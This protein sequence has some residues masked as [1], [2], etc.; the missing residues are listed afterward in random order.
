MIKGI[1]LDANPQAMP[2]ALK[3]RVFNAISFSGGI[4]STYN[5]I[6]V[7]FGLGIM[8]S[9]A[10][11]IGRSLMK[12]V[13]WNLNDGK[14]FP[15][16]W[17]IFVAGS[18][19]AIITR[20]SNDDHDITRMDSIIKDCNEKSHNI[21]IGII[22]L[23]SDGIIDL[24]A[25]VA[26]IEQ[27][28]AMHASV[29]RDLEDL[30]TTLQSSCVNNDHV[31]CVLPI[32][33]IDEIEHVRCIQTPFL[34]YTA[35]VSEKLVPLLVQLGIRLDEGHGKAII[36]TP[37]HTFYVDLNTSTL[38]AVSLP[39]IRCRKYPCRDCFVK[40]CIV[41]ESE[42]KRGFASAELGLTASDVFVLSMIFAIANGQV[43]ASISSQFPRDKPY[44]C[45]K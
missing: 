20:D 4:A 43:P 38:H 44:A 6:G 25:L 45:K 31:A 7:E 32:R 21:N 1:L 23:D 3:G 33:S 14:D 34:N 19:F 10:L 30:M 26:M 35:R 9:L 2:S 12:I 40:V 37:G 13:V 29:A 18:K 42:F 41:L 5:E 24:N 39:C 27:R 28:H 8:E 11:G 22:C 17:R 16:D 36:E 15:L